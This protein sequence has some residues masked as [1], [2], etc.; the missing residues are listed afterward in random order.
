MR[1][2]LYNTAYKIIADYVFFLKCY[3]VKKIFEKVPKIISIYEGENGISAK[4][5][6]NIYK[7]RRLILNERF[8]Y[9]SFYKHQLLHKGKSL[10]LSVIPSLWI[11]ILMKRERGS[12]TYKPLTQIIQQ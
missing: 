9:C 8:S 1:E 10:L 7:E 4:N 11:D 2:V 12:L 5:S 3:S 6:L